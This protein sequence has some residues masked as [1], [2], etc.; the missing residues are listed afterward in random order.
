M[1]KFF[2]LIL[3]F[4][5]LAMW[6]QT[7]VYHSWD[8]QGL[9]PNAQLRVLNIFVNII[10]DVH[11]DTNKIESIYWPQVTDTL[12]EGVNVTGTIP[13]YLLDFMDTSYVCGNPHGC[14]MRLYGESSFDTLQI[15]GDFIVVNVRERR[16]ID[17][18]HSFQ[19]TSIVKAAVDVINEQGFNTI[20]GHNDISYYDC[21]GTGTF[22]YTQI[23]IRN[24]SKAYGRYGVGDGSSGTVLRDKYI[25][26][27]NVNYPFSKGTI[28]CVGGDTI[29]ANPTGVFIHELS[30]QLFG[31]NNFHASGGNHRASGTTITMPFI[32]VQGGYG[33]MGGG[34]SGL[35]S[36]NG[37]ER[38]RMH[39]KHP[40]SPYYIAA[41]NFQNS[42]YVNSDI[43]KSNGGKVFVLRDFVTYGDAIRIQLPYK[44]TVGIP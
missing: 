24:T 9:S 30:H 18:Y 40:S 36:C 41:H 1:R 22:P 7:I 25:T 15:V 21:E 13:T 17:T 4:L 39:W 16:V 3:F 8:G 5:P 23:I 19:P 14:I 20:Y 42:I 29:A 33:L 10:Y 28:Q 26:I 34:N 37:Y 43:S 27:G 6:S 31:G 44:D 32:T 38:W 35:V 2:I 12:K 11:P